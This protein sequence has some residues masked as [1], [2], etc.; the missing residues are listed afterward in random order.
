MP[1]EDAGKR[2]PDGR[3]YLTPWRGELPPLARRC[4]RGDK[5]KEMEILQ[6]LVVLQ[7]AGI[8]QQIAQAIRQVIV[9]IINILTPIINI[10]GVGMVAI[11]LLLGL[12]LR[13]EFLGFRLAIGGALALLTVHIIVPL[14]LGFV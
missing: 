4:W 1:P 9:E 10:L 14:L 2:L 7:A 11:G 3:G 6:I 5:E 8:G 13:Q 12:G